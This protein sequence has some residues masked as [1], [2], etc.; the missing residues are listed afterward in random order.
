M[1]SAKK[2][3]HVRAGEDWTQKQIGDWKIDVIKWI[4]LGWGEL[5]HQEAEKGFRVLV[6]REGG[7]VSGSVIRVGVRAVS[8]G[9]RAGGLLAG[10]GGRLGGKL[11]S[12]WA[13]E[14]A[15]VTH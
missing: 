10:F 3:L 11:R 5:G 7:S 8:R 6:G 1:R 12:G 4:Y 2:A 13:L 15:Y 14:Q 9:F